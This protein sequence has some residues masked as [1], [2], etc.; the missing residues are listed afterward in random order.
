VQRSRFSRR[1]LAAEGEMV[2]SEADF[3][4]RG[5]EPER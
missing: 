5:K 3:A 4:L 1:N 2:F